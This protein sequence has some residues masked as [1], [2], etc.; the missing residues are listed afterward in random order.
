MAL[1]IIGAGQAAHQLATALRQSGYSDHVILVGDEPH[2]PYHRPPLSKAFLTDGLDTERL[3]IATQKFYDQANIETLPGRRVIEID[4][5]AKRISTQFGEQIAYEKLV[6]ATGARNRKLQ[7]S[8]SILGVHSVRSIADAVRLREELGR[9]CRVAVIGGGL[10][11][12]EFACAAQG[13][14]CSVTVVEAGGRIMQRTLSPDLSTRVQAFHAAEGI[15]FKTNTSIQQFVATGGVL[16]GLICSD[17]QF[18]AADLALVSVGVI[19]NTE[20]A[21]RAGLQVQ[22][23][24]VVD[25]NYVTAD[26]AIYAVGDCARVFVKS[27]GESHRHES[28]H[29]AIDQANTLSA[30]IVHNSSKPFRNLPVFWSKQGKLLIHVVGNTVSSD[31][32]LDIGGAAAS[33]CRLCFRQDELIGAECVNSFRQFN[34]VRRLLE[35][36]GRVTMEQLAGTPAPE[37]VVATW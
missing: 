9:A 8:E 16:E 32:F 6:I 7:G 34:H 15:A 11:G 2:L 13:L 29:S 21:E 20:L 12:L 25:E 26:P 36:G 5:V 24:I 22:D 27:R 10:L 1:V 4:R 33:H 3:T 19:P 30:H 35:A 17:G 18:I 23:G 14:G 37:A 31:R 28:V